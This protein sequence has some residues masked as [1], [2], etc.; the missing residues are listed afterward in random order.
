[1]AAV[2]SDDGGDVV[3]AL[4]ALRNEGLLGRDLDQGQYQLIKKP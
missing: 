3:I 2:G 4:E 1:M